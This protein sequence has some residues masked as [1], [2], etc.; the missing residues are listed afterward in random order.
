[1]YI[2]TGL[3]VSIFRKAKKKAWSEIQDHPEVQRLI[4]KGK[5][6]LEANKDAT[7]RSSEAF[8]NNEVEI[9]NWKNK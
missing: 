7:E 5:T 1:M 9:L 4:Q 8:R 3:L 6:Q 2:E